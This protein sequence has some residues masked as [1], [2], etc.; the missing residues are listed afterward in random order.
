MPIPARHAA[1]AIA[2]LA[3]AGW[4]GAASADWIESTVRHGQSAQLSPIMTYGKNDC[5]SYPIKDLKITVPPAHGSAT[6]VTKKVTLGED[7]GVC[8]G[9]A[10]D[11]PWLVYDPT[12]GYVGT[13]SISISWKF[14]LYDNGIFMKYATRDFT[15]NVSP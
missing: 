13:D 8:S 15:I 9:T 1:A 2:I 3:L 7:T 11:A 10:F 14:T 5:A 6:F 4:S 12:P